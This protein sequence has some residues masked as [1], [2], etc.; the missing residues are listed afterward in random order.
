MTEITLMLTKVKQCFR[1]SVDGFGWL[2][3][4]KTVSSFTAKHS[5]T[6]NQ[7]SMLIVAK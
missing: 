1:K 7:A 4:S 5:L 6:N 3:N 2:E